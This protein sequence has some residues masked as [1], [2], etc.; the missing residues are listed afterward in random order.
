M[1]LGL[2]T[3]STAPS[4]GGTRDSTQPVKR[5]CAEMTRIWRLTRN[6][7]RM[8]VARLSST[9]ERLPPDSRWMSTAVTKNRAS[10]SGTRSRELLQRVGK[11]HA[12]VLLVVEQLELRPTGAGISS[13][14]MPMPVVNA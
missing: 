12:E 9:S 3:N 8:T 10:S 11:R 1:W 6:R 7:S 14:T 4:A 2:I 13:A 5:P